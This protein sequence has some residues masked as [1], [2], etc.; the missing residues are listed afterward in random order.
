MNLDF[1]DEEIKYIFFFIP[2]E[3]LPSIDGFCSCFFKKRWSI[4]GQDVVNDIQD[5]FRCGRLLKEIDVIAITLV[6]KIKSPLAVGD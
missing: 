4:V 2:Y 3:K 6:P 5:F 1:I